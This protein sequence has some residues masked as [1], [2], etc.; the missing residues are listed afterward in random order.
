VDFNHRVGLDVKKVPG[1]ETNQ[2]V[3]CL[4][5]VDFASGFPM[6][7]P[8]FEVETG[9]LLRSLFQKGW[10]AWAGAPVEVMLDP[11]RTNISSTFLDP[12]ELSGTRVLT[13]AAEA[14]NQLGK[15]E[16]H[17]HLFEVVLQK[18]LDQVKRTNR[19]E[20][21]QC[22]LSACTSKNEMLNSKGLS[23]AQCFR[24]ESSSSQ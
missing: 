6:M 16:K 21:E 2:V 3:S 15:V 14:H 22:V 20:F 13:T 24:K 7:H 8:F 17:G 5:V 4:N 1:W 11:A 12:L 9:E 10:Q 23:P 19:E 18:V